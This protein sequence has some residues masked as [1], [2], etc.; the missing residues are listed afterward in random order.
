MARVEITVGLCSTPN[1]IVDLFSTAEIPRLHN[2]SSRVQVRLQLF[3]R[4][5]QLRSPGRTPRI[6]AHHKSAAQRQVFGKVSAVTLCEHHPCVVALRLPDQQRGQQPGE[7]AP[8]IP[9]YNLG[10]LDEGS[11]PDSTHIPWMNGQFPTTLGSHS[12]FPLMLIL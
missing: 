5:W 1:I 9:N 3:T 10:I 4:S 12:M 8:A 7:A 6:M 11:A 2:A